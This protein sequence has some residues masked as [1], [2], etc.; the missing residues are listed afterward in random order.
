MKVHLGLKLVRG[1]YSTSRLT[2]AAVLLS[3]IAFISPVQQEERG[4][5]LT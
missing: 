5:N 2:A 4:V 1:Q 3:L